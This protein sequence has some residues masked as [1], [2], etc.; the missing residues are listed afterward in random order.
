M[1]AS[2]VD[3]PSLEAI[4]TNRERLGTRVRTTP[5]YHWDDAPSAADVWLKLEL[6]QRAG[7]FKPR[8][9]LTEMLALDAAQLGRGVTAVSAGNHALAVCYAADVLGTTAKLVMPTT[10]DPARVDGCRRLGGV[11]ELVEDVHAAFDRTREIERTEQ[12][13]FVHPFDGPKIALGTATLGLELMEQVQD[14]D[15]VV[16]PIGG[17]GLCAGVA[18][19][20]KQHSPQC[21]VIGV[22]PVGADSMSRS[23]RSGKPESIPAVETIADSL[24][25]PYALDYSFELCQ[26]FVDRV[27]RVDDDALCVA[28][29][30]LFGALKLAVEPAAAATTAALTALRGELDGRRVALIVCGTN[31]G[32]A[33]YREFLTRGEHLLGP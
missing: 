30:Q 33:R 1:L 3:A 25:A 18:A 17:G 11:V 15:A 23:L 26:R 14:L 2:M 22:E 9:A 24:G 13:H 5:V 32:P 20:V 6:W 29:A 31:I 7:S 28:L 16:V 8:G 21:E 27:V 12:R 10:A 19:A 4:R